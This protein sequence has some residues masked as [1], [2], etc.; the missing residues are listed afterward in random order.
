MQEARNHQRITYRLGV[1]L[2]READNQPQH[3]ETRDIGFGGLYAIGANGLAADQEVRLAI[4][5]EKG[6][7]LHLDAH[8]VRIGHDGAAFEF[9]GNSPASLEVLHTLLTPSWD[10]RNLLDGVVQMA[11][12]YREDDLAGW[13]RLTSLVSDWHRLTQPSVFGD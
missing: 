2:F 13:M 9:S 6:G 12:W 5:R 8:V 7:G 3:C 10:G 4:G 1:D 11:P